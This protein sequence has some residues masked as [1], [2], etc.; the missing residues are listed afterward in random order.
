MKKFKKK[1]ALT[2]PPSHQNDIHWR[3][4]LVIDEHTQRVV[5]IFQNL[6]GFQALSTSK[7][8]NYTGPKSPDLNSEWS[9]NMIR[10]IGIYTSSKG[11]PSGSVGK[12]A[13]KAGGTG[14]VGL[15]SRSGRSLQ[16]SMA[17]HSSILARRIP[18]TEEPGGLQSI[19]SQKVG[20]DKWLSMHAHTS[21]KQA[22][23]S[24]HTS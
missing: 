22:P 2:P 7:P 10:H 5:Q 12:S 19:G 14:D 18:W 15:I 17:T 4:S 1:N 9:A 6:P 16:E 20:Q 23:I 8:K 11:F 21:S 3:N 24:P 13:C